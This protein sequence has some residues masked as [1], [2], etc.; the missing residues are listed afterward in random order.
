[1]SAVRLAVVGSTSLQGN[2]DAAR[3]IEDVLDRYKPDAVISGG[4]LG[5]DTMAVQA[6]RARGIECVEHFPGERGWERGFKPRN[7][8]I[9]HDCTHLV[10]IVAAGSKTYG[11][12][13]TRD[14]AAEMG[15]PTEEILL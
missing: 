1:M 15:K 8:R 7:L 14:R 6:A 12:G 9:A 3:V 2:A 10:R 11:S 4:A 13:W 5:I